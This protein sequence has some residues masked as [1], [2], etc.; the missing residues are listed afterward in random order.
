[1]KTTLKAT[2]SKMHPLVD[3]GANLTHHKYHRDLEDVLAR[4]TNA[5]DLYTARV[6]TTTTH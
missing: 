2:L 5:G 6:V 4:A 3:I 1:M